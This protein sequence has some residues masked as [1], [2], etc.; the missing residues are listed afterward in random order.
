M[1]L[2]NNKIQNDY[3]QDRDILDP[4]YLQKNYFQRS[5]NLLVQGFFTIY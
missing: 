3:I 4:T 2:L 5:L 1:H